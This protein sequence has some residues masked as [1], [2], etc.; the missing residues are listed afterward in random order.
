LQA[1]KEAEKAAKA[2][3]VPETEDEAEAGVEP[4][5]EAAEKAETASQ[6]ASAAQAAEL[7][8]VHRLTEQD[9][10]SGGLEIRK[11]LGRQ[12]SSP[13]SPP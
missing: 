9:N 1:L 5:A 3:F 8:M 11:S 10:Q 6:R 2:L 7:A 13:D 12:P 4:A